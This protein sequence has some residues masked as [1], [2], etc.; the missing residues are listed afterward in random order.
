MKNF[1]SPETTNVLVVVVLGV[2]VTIEVVHYLL[3]FV[4]NRRTKKILE[5]VK[6]ILEK[7]PP[8]LV[9]LKRI[10]GVLGCEK[11]DDDGKGPEEGGN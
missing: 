10:E 5:D 11:K 4:D 1:L 7:S 9:K 3:G 8:C 2:H 6:A